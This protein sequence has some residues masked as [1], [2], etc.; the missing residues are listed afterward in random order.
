MRASPAFR[1]A[2]FC[3][4]IFAVIAA[5]LA[6]WPLWLASRGLDATEIGALSAATLAVRVAATPLLGMLTYRTEQRRLILGLTLLLLAG[7]ALFVPAYGFVA[8]LPIAVVTGTC[9]SALPPLMD[10]A[11]MQGGLDYGRVRLWG[12]LSFL[13]MTL[14]IGRALL[15]APPDRLLLFV[16]GSGLVLL[17][18]ALMLPRAARAGAPPRPG[19][20]RIL[21]GRRHALFFLAVTLIQASHAAHNQF[22]ALYWRSLGYSTETIGWL[23]ADT[24]IAE[25]ILFYWG[26][27]LVARLTPLQLI[28]LGGV[29]GLVRWTVLGTATAL[30]LLFA[31]QSLHCLSFA[32]AHLGALNYLSRHFPPPHGGAA[33]I[34]YSAVLALGFGAASLLSGALYQ[35]EGGLVFLAM[36]LMSGSG[37]LA[38]LRL[39]RRYGG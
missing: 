28:L 15:G 38:T 2:L 22:S 13:L 19:G 35:I 32:A 20:W 6:F 10:G 18:S 36:A 21:L 23:W 26:R 24:C 14:A 31:V 17:L 9:L 34:A 30:P 29:A 5:Q 1:Y 7:F 8:L 33:Q 3:A 27:A 12:T 25:L 37:A 16:L 4:A 39:T 11:V